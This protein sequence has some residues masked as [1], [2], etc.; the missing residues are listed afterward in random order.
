VAI[1]GPGYIFGL[2]GS[3]YT[4][5]GPHVQDE[6]DQLKSLRFSGTNVRVYDNAFLMGGRYNQ[7]MWDVTDTA[8]NPTSSFDHNFL[9]G[10]WDRGCELVLDGSL[11]IRRFKNNYF[12]KSPRRRADGQTNG[13]RPYESVIAASPRK[14]S[15]PQIVN[16]YF[17]R[18]RR[19]S[20]DD[21]GQNPETPRS[22]AMPSATS[23]SGWLTARLGGSGTYENKHVLQHLR[24]PRRQH[25]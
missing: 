7:I 5:S 20:R 15:A 2:A 9:A 19:R 11:Y 16:N 12:G 3:N 8:V 10:K 4:V 25:R 18:R 6:N 21:L 13:W 14:S 24:H 17:R 23:P 1:S 22:P